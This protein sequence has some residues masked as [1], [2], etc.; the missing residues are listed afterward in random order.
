M[1]TLLKGS[2]E[3]WSKSPVNVLIFI[4]LL[5]T[6]SF[7]TDHLQSTILEHLHTCSTFPA[8]VRNMSGSLL[9]STT[10]SGPRG[11]VVFAL[12]SSLVSNR[13]P[14]NV[15]LSL[16]NSQK[17]HGAKS[18]THFFMFPKLKMTLKGKRFE[19]N[20]DLK[21]NTTDPRRPLKVVE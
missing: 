5:T 12:R 9:Y 4:K 15:I 17:S 16:G 14:F 2:Y 8:T 13:F 1:I 11:S 3:G 10:F 7:E 21:A 20:E 19:T 18:G 6:L